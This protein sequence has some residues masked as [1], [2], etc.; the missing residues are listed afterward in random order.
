VNIQAGS[1]RALRTVA[2]DAAIDLM[3]SLTTRGFCG[4]LLRQVNAWVR[5]DHCS[6]LRLTP[7]AGVQLFGAESLASFV[8]HGARA[9]VSYVDRF[10]RLDP[11]RRALH[12]PGAQPSIVM[13]RERPA[14]LADANYRRACFDEPG[15]VDRLSVAIPDGRGG[16]IALDMQRQASSGEF[17]D[18]DRETLAA[19][20]PLLTAACA[21]H[22]ELLVHGGADAATW[23]VRLAAACPAATGRELDVAASLL[24][25][26]TMREAAGALGIAHSS[27]VTYAERAYARLGVANLRELRARFTGNGTSGREATRHFASFNAR[28]LG[29]APVH[30]TAA[31]V[32]S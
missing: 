6:L 28:A 29:A 13:R 11:I 21:R 30:A 17:S 10:H 27:V 2:L 3:R 9:I 26:R 24:A 19:V 23:R 16:L 1:K 32:E 8:S 5:V 18:E 4:A 7:G 14:E 12:A 20:A 31:G 22:V 25:G 15:I